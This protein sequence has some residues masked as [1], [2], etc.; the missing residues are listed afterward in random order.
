QRTPA[1]RHQGRPLPVVG[2]RVPYLYL[3]RELP[4]GP[5]NTNRR[6]Q[7][8][9]SQYLKHSVLSSHGTLTSKQG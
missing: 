7:G 4:S 3:A 9:Q 1:A 8:D 2:D 5:V 6:Y